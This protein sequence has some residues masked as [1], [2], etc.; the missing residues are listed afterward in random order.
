MAALRKRWKKTFSA[1]LSFAASCDYHEYK[2]SRRVHGNDFMQKSFVCGGWNINKRIAD[3]KEWDLIVSIDPRSIINS[4]KCPDRIGNYISFSPL[5]QQQWLTL[6]L[7]S[8]FVIS[9][10]QNE[11]KMTVKKVSLINFHPQSDK[12]HIRSLFVPASNIVCVHDGWM[13]GKTY[14]THEKYILHSAALLT[15]SPSSHKQHNKQE[16]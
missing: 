13:E 8:L 16:P 11:M 9:I 4:G 14:Q 15:L 1:L 3:R 2:S 12:R 10:P 5:L 7:L 6:V